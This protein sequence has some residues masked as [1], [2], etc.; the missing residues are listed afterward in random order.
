M[1]IST[2]HNLDILDKTF[3]DGNIRTRNAWLV[4][5]IET[6]SGFLKILHKHSPRLKTPV[7][8][9]QLPLLVDRNFCETWKSHRQTNFENLD[10][11]TGTKRESVRWRGVDHIKQSRFKHFSNTWTVQMRTSVS[12]WSG[13]W[14]AVYLKGCVNKTYRWGCVHNAKNTHTDPVHNFTANHSRGSKSAVVR[15]M[16]NGWI[17]LLQRRTRMDEQRPIYKT[18]ADSWLPRLFWQPAS[19]L[20]SMHKN[21]KGQLGERWR[22]GSNVVCWRHYCCYFLFVETAVD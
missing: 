20:D 17:I 2:N 8:A 18:F 6:E 3:H 5:S 7:S 14:T 10:H 21:W 22:K 11:F 15:S 12:L 9:L 4:H 13:S 1:N 16:Y 19:P